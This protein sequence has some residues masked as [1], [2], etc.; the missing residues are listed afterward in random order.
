MHYQRV[1]RWC[2]TFPSATDERYQARTLCNPYAHAVQPIPR[3]PRLWP[4][5]I[6]PQTRSVPQ[7]F[8]THSEHRRFGDTRRHRDSQ[9][10]PSQLA[11]C[12][13][14]ALCAKHRW[15][16]PF[17]TNAAPHQRFQNQSETTIGRT[18]SPSPA[19]TSP[20]FSHLLRLQACLWCP[21]PGR[22]P[23]SETFDEYSRQGSVSDYDD[24]LANQISWRC[25]KPTN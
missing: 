4:Y 3:L 1:P 9:Q 6:R 7:S 19:R 16:P 24:L 22:R 10:K 5:G 21:Q 15:T 20:L 25:V 18:D 17:R 8:A 2:W 23:E 12:E 11:K 14:R 13:A